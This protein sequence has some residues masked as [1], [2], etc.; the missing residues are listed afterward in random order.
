MV[1]HSGQNN[2]TSTLISLNNQQFRI[3]NG[4]GKKE[5]CEN[6]LERK[7]IERGKYLIIK[8]KF[9]SSEVKEKHDLV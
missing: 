9:N 3:E 7:R 2:T 4:E 5:K 1:A 8:K 6:E